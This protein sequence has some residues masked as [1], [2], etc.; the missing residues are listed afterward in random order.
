MSGWIIAFLV[1]YGANFALALN[2]YSSGGGAIKIGL[3]DIF[4]APMVTLFL[5]YMGGAFSG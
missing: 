4:L 2:R 3:G 1:W 5:L